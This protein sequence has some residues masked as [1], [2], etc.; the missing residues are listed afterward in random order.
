[1]Y[2]QF[3][4]ISIFRKKC[5]S[6]N[7]FFNGMGGMAVVAGWWGIWDLVTGFVVATIW[8]RMAAKQAAKG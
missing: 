3:K 8:A 4:I 5:Y 1:M 7:P 2:I 6:A